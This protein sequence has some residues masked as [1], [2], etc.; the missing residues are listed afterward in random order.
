MAKEIATKNAPAAV[1]PYS[2]ALEVGSLVFASGQIPLD[3]ASGTIVGETAA[4]QADRLVLPENDAV[5]LNIY[6]QR[7]FFLN[8]QCPA[9]FDGQDDPSQLVHLADNP[10]RFHNILL[11]SISSGVLVP[12]RGQ[13]VIFIIIP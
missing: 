5:P 7:I 4:E 12:Q 8:S 9:H 1:G 10:R 11:S 6:L 2:Q 3:P 13:P